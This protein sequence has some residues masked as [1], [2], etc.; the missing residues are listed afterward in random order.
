MD[1]INLPSLPHFTPLPVFEGGDMPEIIRF[2]LSAVQYLLNLTY[3]RPEKGPSGFR[4][5]VLIQLLTKTSRI[6]D[7]DL[8]KKYIAIVIDDHIQLIQD[9][10]SL[11]IKDNLSPVQFLK[12][13]SEEWRSFRLSRLALE[14][15]LFNLFKETSSSHSSMISN[16]V[17][18]IEVNTKTKIM[19]FCYER[20]KKMIMDPLREK[21]QNASHILMGKYRQEYLNSVADADDSTTI[22][23]VVNSYDELSSLSDANPDTPSIY[24]SDWE[25]PFLENTKEFYQNLVSSFITSHHISEYL[26]LCRRILDLE[27]ISSINFITAKTTT[28]HNALINDIVVINQVVHLQSAIADFVEKS[29][30]PHLQVLYRLFERI[31]DLDSLMNIFVEFCQNEIA[32]VFIQLKSE[33]ESLPDAEKKTVLPGKYCTMFL[34]KYYMLCDVITNAFNS[35]IK[36]STHLSKIARERFNNNVLYNC[37]DPTESVALFVSKY[38]DT[39]AVNSNRL[40]IQELISD[41][42]MIDGLLTLF[43]FTASKD[44]FCKRYRMFFMNRLLRSTT[45]NDDIEKLLIEKMRTVYDT[46]FSQQLVIMMRDVEQSKE[47]YKPKEEDTVIPC[48]PTV[49]TSSSWP[50]TPEEQ[51]LTM[52]L[53]GKLELLSKKYSN[54]FESI[55]DGKKVVWLHERSTAVIGL[56]IGGKPYLITMNHFQASVMVLIYDSKPTSPSTSTI[57]TVLNLPE[58]WVEAALNSLKGVQLIQQNAKTQQWRINPQFKANQIKLNASVRFARPVKDLEV[59]PSI[60]EE[61]EIKTQAAIVRIMKA[62]R[63]L[64]H[65]VLQEDVTKQT[66]RFFPQNAE[67]I[68]RQIEKLLNGSEKFIERVD[69]KTYRYVTEDN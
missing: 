24:V 52:V 5:D 8:V 57:S 33:L 31:E 13:Y 3:P 9:R 51:A 47:R 12:L 7:R 40:T 22:R 56:R 18:N 29:D 25:V 55:T 42:M 10:L 39:I 19:L 49:L 26:D 21:I 67:R 60:E 43:N 17:H 61:R 14:C 63:V 27:S 6:Q 34:T 59:D 35:N 58:E 23:N 62:R 4:S 45:V 41:R 37:D 50:L 2:I 11:T 30:V 16:S 54:F 48:H 44:V 15:C 1:R 69:N 38:G 32:N 68:R 46:Q 36:F 53:P 28:S 65:A 20:W 64:E 66:S